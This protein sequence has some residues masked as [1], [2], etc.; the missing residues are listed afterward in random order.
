VLSPEDFVGATIRAPTSETTYALFE[1]L[2]A[3]PDDLGGSAAPGEPYAIGVAD[4]SVAAAELSFSLTVALP[5]HAV[6]TGNV[7]LFP[8]V[9]TIVANAEAFDALS[10]DLQL[11]LRQAAGATRDWAVANN[12]DDPDL[13][14][15]YCAGGGHIAL[16][17]DAEIEALRDATEVVYAALERD[18]ATV[19]M[20]DRI[21]QLAVDAGPA[22]GVEA[23]A[24]DDSNGPRPTAEFSG[25]FPDGVYRVEISVERL[26]SAAIDRPTALQHAGVWTM[27]F[28]GGELM[29]RDVNASTGKVSEGEGVYCL[30]DGRVVLGLLG[31]PPHCGDFWSGAWTLEGDQ[32]RFTDVESGHG[33]DL[34][35][36]TLFGGQPW[37]KVE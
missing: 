28:S 29:V 6:A 7:T 35:I 32:L 13:A 36:E 20:I 15:E 1:A 18:P 16:A 22:V 9:N 19:E 14:E 17:S 5:A 37:T 10:E 27:T 34:L 8:K 25:D 31:S 4:G 33:F 26:T 12:R 23:C 3:R 24:P 21:R 30:E 2:G 11:A